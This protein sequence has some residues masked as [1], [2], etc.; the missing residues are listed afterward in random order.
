MYYCKKV[1]LVDL[2]TY[3]R[4]IKFEIDLLKFKSYFPARCT[5]VN[6]ADFL[7]ITSLLTTTLD[8][9]KSNNRRLKNE[10]IFLE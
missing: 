4:K 10:S 9:L 1:G 5:Q 8:L 7:R 2:R 6:R 3:G